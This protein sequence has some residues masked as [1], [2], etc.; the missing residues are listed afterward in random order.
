MLLVMTGLL[1]HALP[2]PLQCAGWRLGKN[3]AGHDCI[4]HEWKVRNFRA[5]LDLFQR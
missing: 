1:P 4:S 2:F 5:G 3:A